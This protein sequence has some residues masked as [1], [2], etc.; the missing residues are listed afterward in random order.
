MGCAD[1]GKRSVHGLMT[2][3]DPSSTNKHQSI[4]VRVHMAVMDT[5][6]AARSGFHEPLASARSS[7]IQ[8][9]EPA[10]TACYVALWA[11]RVSVATNAVVFEV[12]RRYCN[13]IGWTGFRKQAPSLFHNLSLCESDLFENLGVVFAGCLHSGIPSAPFPLS[14][15]PA[16]SRCR[17]NQ[18]ACSFRNCSI[19]V[20]R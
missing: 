15:Y 6:H 19:M 2:P 3:S 13:R 10:S 16:Q 4:P 8:F 18:P 11:Q 12:E 5:A 9:D 20:C 1:Q 14:P 7:G 17:A